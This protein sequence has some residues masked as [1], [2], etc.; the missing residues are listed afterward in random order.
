MAR[1]KK[2]PDLSSRV[3]EFGD[4]SKKEQQNAVALESGVSENIPERMA[5]AAQQHLKSPSPNM[6]AKGYRY[7]EAA[8]QMKSKSLTM[9]KMVSARKNAFKDAVTGDI[10]LPEESVSGQEFYFSK[11]K[12]LDKITGNIDTPIGRVVSATGRL[13]IQTKPD[14]E[15]QALAALTKAHSQGSVSFNESMVGALRQ[16]GGVVPTELH[17]KTV[18]FKNIPGNI[19]HKMTEP[20]IR[21]TI[22]PHVDNVNVED[23]AK[24]SMRNNLQ[25]AHE[26]LQGLRDTSPTANPKL[27][28]YGKAHELSVPDSPEHREYQLRGYH[29][30]RVMRGE[31]SAAQQMFDFEGLRSSNEGILSN[32]FQTPNDSWMLANQ[33]QQPQEVRKVAGDINLTTKKGATKRG[34]SVSVGVGNPDIT[35]AAIQ[36]AVGAEA[37]SRAAREIQSDYN[38]DYTIPATLVQ[39]GVWAAE[40]RR[41]GQDSPFNARTAVKKEKRQKRQGKQLSLFK[42]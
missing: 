36:H 22:Q 21:S 12:D 28:A 32:Q 30:G 41:A 16:V 8:P 13:S 18:P 33:R 7:Q 35:P 31:E 34:R 37:T 3:L 27:F 25:F 26:S 20:S 39:E 42:D 19:V 38:I 15:A 6:R 23:M 5:A 2:R 4:L 10:R 9:D 24:T 11:R 40:R 17:G 14:K 29:L 1:S